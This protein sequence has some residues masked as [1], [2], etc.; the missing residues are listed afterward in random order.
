MRRQLGMAAVL[1]ATLSMAACLD[2]ETT[3]TLYL[4]PDGQV[5]WVTFESHVRSDRK[6][7]P[8]RNTE[9]AEYLTAALAGTNDVARGLGALE[10]DLVR[11][12]V[13]RRER[14]F[15]VM[16]EARFSS[17]EALANRIMAAFRIPGDAYI[18]RDGDAVTLHVHLD[19]RA[20]E[21]ETED[22]GPENDSPVAALLGEIASYRI[23]L[24]EGSFSDPVG[25]TLNG[26]GT[27]ATPVAPSDEEIKALGVLDLALTWRR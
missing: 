25:F 5:A 24:T 13:L 14:P 20:V 1:V 26:D 11:T 4:S 21:S 6:D 3:H 15:T 16:T 27:A 2:K 10:P 12:R 18:S 19:L 7:A 9:E 8:S 23:V 22:A 17:V